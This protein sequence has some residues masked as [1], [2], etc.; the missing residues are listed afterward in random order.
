M[1]EKTVNITNF[2]GP[3]SGSNN[4]PNVFD[5]GGGV[6]D[7]G[8][9]NT[10]S[11]NF[12]NPQ[13]AEMYKQQ[14]IAR[15]GVN[16]DK[17]PFVDSI[18]TSLFGDLIDRRKDL[19]SQRIQEINDL[20]ARQA[21]G[22]PSLKTGLSYTQKDFEAGR[23]TNQGMVRELPI[24]GIESFARSFIPG[25]SLLPRGAAP[26]K[27]Q[28]YREA[29][30]KAN[31]PGIMSMTGDFLTDI[32]NSAE[33]VFSGKPVLD[34]L[35]GGIDFLNNSKAGST[36]EE[37]AKEQARIEIADL[38]KERLDS[39]V[40]AP[41]DRVKT[42][43]LDPAF[44][45]VDKTTAMD[46]GVSLAAN[47]NIVMT[48]E[49]DAFRQD[50]ANNRGIFSLA[51]AADLQNNQ[52]A[53]GKKTG[54]TL[55]PEMPVSFP[56]GRSGGYNMS[57]LSSRGDAVKPNPIQGPPNPFVDD[58][59]S[60]ISRPF[61]T[62]DQVALRNSPDGYYF[63]NAFN[64]PLDA[65]RTSDK[66]RTPINEEEV[67]AEEFAGY[68]F[69]PI[70]KSTDPVEYINKKDLPSDLQGIVSLNTD[71]DY[72]STIPLNVYF[73]QTRRGKAEEN[74]RLNE[75]KKEIE[76]LDNLP[77][78]YPSFDRANLPLIY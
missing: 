49:I 13:L 11:Q 2:I 55:N 14:E 37:V 42:S 78:S 76:R 72:G 21:F 75:I 54:Q 9:G 27:S 35:F 52:I 6:G 23:D 10:R 12:L 26:E 18:F 7:F 39:L 32:A 67:R 33:R 34:S 30:A 46:A 19:G 31:A 4:V 57:V 61:A 1:I 41:I 8:F 40:T 74:F 66:Y 16:L 15:T 3:L 24:G 77:K 20:R 71:L 5:L 59:V 45:N 25:A 36:V 65:T 68:N 48:P 29:Q 58:I 28:M 63:A 38:E 51:Q 22:L 73:D 50:I 44:M 17:N 43:E 53:A 56:Y 70:P 62:T 47:P 69:S 64:R 60:P